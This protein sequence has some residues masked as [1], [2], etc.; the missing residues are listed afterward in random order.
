MGM[1]KTMKDKT[2]GDGKVCG[3]R[4]GVIKLLLKSLMKICLWSV[5]GYWKMQVS[6]VL[7]ARSAQW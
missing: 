3:R 2:R 1:R 7:E 6:P 5:W 4:R